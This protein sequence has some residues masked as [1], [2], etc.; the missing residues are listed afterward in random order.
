MKNIYIFLLLIFSTSVWAQS[1]PL[2]CNDVKNGTFIYAGKNDYPVSYVRNGTLQKEIIPQRKETILW[3]VT[4]IN[5]CTYSLKYISGGEQ[6]TKAE[7]DIFRKH[8]IVSEIVQVTEDYYTFRSALDKITNKTILEDTLWIKQRKSASGKSVNNPHIDSLF[9]EKINKAKTDTSKFATL[10]VYRP[11]KFLN[12]LMNYDLYLNGVSL[13]TIS[14]NCRYMIKIKQE[15]TAKL[16]AKIRGQEAE[17]PL[18]VKFGQE[19]YLRC[20]CTWGLKSEP[21]LSLVEKKTGKMEFDSD[22]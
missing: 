10:Y 4:W 5:D 14:N 18:E 21:V 20:A 12:S 22:K 3:E 9:A 11:V 1:T 7:Q 16:T 15:G 2:T 17:I 13:C 6:R 19:Y 8:T